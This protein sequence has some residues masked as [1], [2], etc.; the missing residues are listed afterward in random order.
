MGIPVGLLEKGLLC[1]VEVTNDKAWKLFP[2]GIQPRPAEPINGAGNALS[3]LFKMSPFRFCPSIF[4]KVACPIFSRHDF[5]PF[6]RDLTQ[7][8]TAVAQRGY[9]AVGCSDS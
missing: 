8:S 3:Y 7:S 9:T 4:K 2:N 6:S 5:P 1:P